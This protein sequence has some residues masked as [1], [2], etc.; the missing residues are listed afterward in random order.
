MVAGGLGCPVLQYLAASGVGQIGIVDDDTVSLN[1]LQR[2][3]LYSTE[4][5]GCDK[6]TVAKGKLHNLNPQIN[7]NS[8]KK[9]N[10]S[11]NALS[12]LLKKS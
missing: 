4:D 8:F 12:M 11:S 5:I 3:V 1:N 7:I 2:Q 6:V 9:R 10:D